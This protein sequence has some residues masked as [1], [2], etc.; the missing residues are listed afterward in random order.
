MISH[1]FFHHIQSPTIENLVHLADSSFDTES[2]VN[3]EHTVLCM[4]DFKVS[5]HTSYYFA[6]RLA[7][8]AE[9]TEKEQSFMFFLLGMY[10]HVYDTCVIQTIL[11]GD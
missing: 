9:M 6:T 11:A 5:V 8:A 3:M 4:L 7:L 2:L 10:V 1:I